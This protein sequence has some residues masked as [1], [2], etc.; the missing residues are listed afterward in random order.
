MGRQKLLRLSSDLDQYSHIHLVWNP[1][2]KIIGY[3]DLEHQEY[4]NVGTFDAFI[5]E[6]VPFIEAILN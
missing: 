4:A 6:P 1:S 5:E 3:V 2:K